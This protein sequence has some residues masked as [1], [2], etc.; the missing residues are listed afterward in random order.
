MAVFRGATVLCSAVGQYL[1]RHAS[2][3]VLLLDM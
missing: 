1:A 3:I 2:F